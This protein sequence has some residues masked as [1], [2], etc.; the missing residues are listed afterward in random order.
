MESKK[1]IAHRGMSTLAPEN[2]MAAFELMPAYNINWLETDIAI[3]QDE[4]LVIMHDTEISRTT[5]GTGKIS[6]MTF[7]Q[8]Q[9]Y[10]AGAWFDEQY[11]AEKVPTFDQLI[12]FLNRT[13]INVNLE[14]K[15]VT[16]KDAKQLTNSMV[17][18]LA[19]KIN[20]IN[21]AC[22]VVISS[23]YPDI[24][25]QLQKL[26][27]DLEYAS[28]FNPYTLPF[29][30]PITKLIGTKII[31]PDNRHLNQ[32]QVERMKQAGFEVNVWTVDRIDRANQLFNWGVDG[33]FTDIGQDFPS[34]HKQKRHASHFLTTWF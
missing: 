19:V 3:T 9:Q 21:P 26:R 15:S 7:A 24:L 30:R 22:R 27:P 12:D 8:L 23:F 25:M 4:K 28:L 18:Q 16:G 1:I 33:V 10:S 32:R 13:Q 14:I 34:H 11:C 20:R 2:T 17:Q 6:E 31:H 29:W 5:N